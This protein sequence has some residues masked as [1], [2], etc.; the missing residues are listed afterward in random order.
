VASQAASLVSAAFQSALAI[1]L[2]ASLTCCA[3]CG[4]AAWAAGPGWSGP[5]WG[6]GGTL[7]CAYTHAMGL[8]T[9]RKKAEKRTQ[10]LKVQFTT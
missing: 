9:N 10:I 1:R 3:T 5:D 6:A 4:A 7:D 8:A 2:S